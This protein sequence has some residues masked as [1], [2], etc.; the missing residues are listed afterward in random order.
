M[1]KIIIILIKTG[2]LTLFIALLCIADT[3]KN[4]FIL[5]FLTIPAYFPKMP[6]SVQNPITLEGIELGRKLFYD[7]TLSAN[8][9]LSCASCHQQAKGFTDNIALSNIGFS[10]K[11]LARN[12]P[13]LANIAWAKNLFWDGGANNLES[14]SVTPLTSIDEMRKDLHILKTELQANLDYVQRFKNAFPNNPEISTQN[15]LRALAQFERTIISANS[16]YDKY[17]SK[18]NNIQL[19][20]IEL[21]GLKIIRQKCTPCHDTE[22]FTDNNFHNNG[23]DTDDYFASEFIR[24]GRGRI[25][26]NKADVG[27]YRT[28]SLRNLLFTA[29]YM[30]DGRFLSI[31][32]VLNHYSKGVKYSKTLDNKLIAKNRQLGIILSEG[33]KKAII[34]FLNTLNDYEL[35]K[36]TKL[37]N[38]F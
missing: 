36:N 15:I 7:K 18:E 21:Q 6:T 20:E 11:K 25:T 33:E 37:S 31:E 5:D 23:L 30:H 4:N 3:E 19:E 14:L 16:K 8:G 17:L 10:K 9:D 26:E 2:L 1:G 24:K 22:L 13:S 38:S 12:A 27:K 28:P 29:P 35:Q 32:E 34:T